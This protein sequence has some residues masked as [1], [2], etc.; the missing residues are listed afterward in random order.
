MEIPLYSWLMKNPPVIEEQVIRVLVLR[1]QEGDTEAFGKLY[2]HFFL[3]IYRY[4]SFRAP[5]DLV[6]DLVADIFVKAWEKLHTYKVRKEIP[7][8]AWLFRIARYTVIDAYRT[9]RDFEE[10]SDELV[11]D[12]ELNR[13]DHRTNKQDLLRIVRKALAELPRRYREVLLLSYVA[14]LPGSEVAKAMRSSEGGVR[15]LKMR[16]L[17]KLESLLPLEMVQRA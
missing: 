11:D 17:R 3:P 12:D 4:T 15:I 14:E 6:E 13:A 16:A 7:F 2:D 5:S 1:A 9:Q 10:V 8:G